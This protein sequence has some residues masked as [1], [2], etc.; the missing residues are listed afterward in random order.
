M[1]K[2]TVERSIWIAAPRERVWRAITDPT[3]LEKW[4]ATNFKWEIPA[5]HVGATVTFY[6]SDADILHATIEVVD[7]L[8]QFQLGWAPVEQ[9]VVL[10]TTFLIEEENGGTRAT[11]TETGY[12]L[13]PEDQRRQWIDSTAAG[14]TMS[15]ENLKAHVEGRPIPH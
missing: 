13:L 7:P 6:H 4:Y 15:M 5:L 3:Q 14:Y 12:E 1:E 8:R 2:G 11:I 9:G 10:V